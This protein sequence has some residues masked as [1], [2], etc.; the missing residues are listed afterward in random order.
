MLTQE[1]RVESMHRADLEVLGARWFE[2][3]KD[4][5]RYDVSTAFERRV[6]LTRDKATQTDEGW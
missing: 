6:E 3:A 4:V 1:D 5:T 2:E